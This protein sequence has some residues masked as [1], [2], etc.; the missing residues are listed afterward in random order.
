MRARGRQR[1]GSKGG[2]CGDGVPKTQHRFADGCPW[3]L[4]PVHTL[5]I[6][7]T[8]L[9][10][11]SCTSAFLGMTPYAKLS[12]FVVVGRLFFSLF[13]MKLSKA[14]SIKPLL[15]PGPFEGFRRG[16]ESTL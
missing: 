4:L 14:H 11:C 15:F 2:N 7:G 16:N 1:E 3:L 10:A 13:W 8:C 9:S 6:K 12:G 5:L